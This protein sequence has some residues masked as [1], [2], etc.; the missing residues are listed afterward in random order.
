MSLCFWHILQL[1]VVCSLLLFTISHGNFSAIY[2]YCQSPNHLKHY[3]KLISTFPLLLMWCS[4]GENS[5]GLH[6][7]VY[8]LIL[9]LFI[10]CMM[11][12]LNKLVKE[13]QRYSECFCKQDWVSYKM[14]R[15]ARKCRN[16]TRKVVFFVCVWVT[17]LSILIA[18][19][20]KYGAY[21][22]LWVLIGIFSI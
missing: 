17:G 7:S 16:C 22:F 12:F 19:L 5:W 10:D 14:R 18:Y 11:P 6:C 9:F 15:L 4:A 2:R 3:S 13:Y 1:G 21:L 8:T 20:C